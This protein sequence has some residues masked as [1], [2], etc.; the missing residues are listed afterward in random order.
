MGLTGSKKRRAAFRRQSALCTIL[1]GA[2]ICQSCDRLDKQYGERPET[3]SGG[4][5]NY[6][7]ESTIP[8]RKDPTLRGERELL[9]KQYLCHP[10]RRLLM[11][12]AEVH[13]FYS[14]EKVSPVNATFES[15]KWM[16]RYKQIDVGTIPELAS[17]EDLID[18]LKNWTKRVQASYPHQKSGSFGPY[19]EI[20]RSIERGDVQS[21]RSAASEIEEK[22]QSGDVGA[23]LIERASNLLVLLSAQTVDLMEV[24]DVIFAKAAAMTTIAE[25][26]A[27]RSLN[28]N[29]CLLAVSMGHQSRKNK[30]IKSLP[31]DDPIR[32]FVE[33]RD[34]ELKERAEDRQDRIARILYMRAL[35][36][37]QDF[38]PAVAAARRFISQ[39]RTMALPALGSLIPTV[40]PGTGVPL[41]SNL[42]WSTS[43][44]LSNKTVAGNKWSLDQDEW[45]K[46][47]EALAEDLV[48]ATF[49][50][51][52]TRALKALPST[53]NAIIFGADLFQGYFEAYFCSSIYLLGSQ[54]LSMTTI[55]S[56]SR[57]LMRALKSSPS[58]RIAR[59]ADWLELRLK[60]RSGRGNDRELR[61]DVL[62]CAELGTPA[63]AA[64]FADAGGFMSTQSP[65]LRHNAAIALFELADA[66]PANLTTLGQILEQSLI[67]LRRARQLFEAAES[68]GA[69]LSYDYQSLSS[70]FSFVAARF[71]IKE[72]AEREG[73]TKEA[74]AAGL[75]AD[76]DTLG[77]LSALPV[78]ARLQVM[79]MMESRLPP[80]VITREFLAMIAEEK[81]KWWIV[82]RY[83]RWLLKTGKAD[84]AQEAVNGWLKTHSNSGE[85]DVT[86]AR[87]ILSECHYRLGH[88]AEGL[89][90]IS[91]TLQSEDL[92]CMKMQTILLQAGGRRDEAMQWAR[93]LLKSS[94]TGGA[95]ATLACAIFWL[96]EQ[97]R[98]AGQTLVSRSLT[99]E[100]WDTL[101]SPVFFSIFKEKD[102]SM[103]LA[104][105]AMKRAGID[106]AAL[107]RL[108]RYAYSIGKPK[109]ALSIF[110]AIEP[111]SESEQLQRAMAIYTCLRAFSSSEKA[112]DW[113]KSAL[114]YTTRRMAAD[115]AYTSGYGELL[116]NFVPLG[117]PG[118]DDEEVWILRALLSV[119]NKRS[120]PAQVQALKDHFKKDPTTYG[121]VGRYL[122]DLSRVSEVESM[123]PKDDQLAFVAH[124]LAVKELYSGQ[125]FLT[126]AEW[127]YLAAVREQENTWSQW[128]WDELR[129]IETQMLANNISLET[130]TIPKMFV[131]RPKGPP[132]KER[133]W[134]DTVLLDSWWQSHQKRAI[135]V[136]Q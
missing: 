83:C 2:T 117:V 85:D 60:W 62:A 102:K 17:F 24:A 132:K 104:L 27:A 93:E 103:A 6:R 87:A 94:G 37:R 96:N 111:R 67:H 79:Q 119:K 26:S 46:E 64:L 54:Y 70:P 92:N 95:P 43:S 40:F 136:R 128:S 59:I 68:A 38:R 57:R 65:F 75:I 115:I 108:A 41:A 116:W 86:S 74:R 63:R 42:L 61:N 84:K 32:L 105:D 130:L 123:A 10:D 80:Q 49:V 50:T 34:A 20:D 7:I 44:E 47:N 106:N 124:G 56:D 77:N 69:R 122:V 18:L 127:H 110:A 31:A 91:P 99:N 51:D 120:S 14:G 8:V 100:D 90:V 98:F 72:I 112:L 30:R 71:A 133:A 25:A 135:K 19:P 58:R 88:T 97:Y 53:Q 101:V 16:V 107:S 9:R 3:V 29:W 52:F 28:R 22:W 21:L 13:H 76:Q 73:V 1:V 66:R 82:S 121:A 113:L 114:P 12:V 11:A 125:D 5:Q 4:E 126:S 109:R 36:M 129:E 89:S 134:Q 55:A 131:F 39:D 35:S 78:M 15:G 118:T 48:S 33:N 23:L 45:S 81:G